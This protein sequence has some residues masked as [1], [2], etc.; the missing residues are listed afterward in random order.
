MIGGKGLATDAPEEPANGLLTTAEL[1]ARPD[2]RL[3]AT[4]VSPSMRN[5][6]GPGGTADVEPRV[7]QVLVVLAD[8][9][10]HVVTRHTLF[11]R[12]WGGVYVGDDSLNRAVAAVR[13][14]AQDVAAGGFEI[15]TIPRTGYRLTIEGGAES[16]AGPGEGG[17]PARQPML[18]RRAAVGTGIAAVAVAGGG[19]GLWWSRSE[20]SR[21]FE[22]LLERGEKALDFGD[23][24]A[25]PYRYFQR[26]A[27]LRPDD[28]RAQAYLAYSQALRAD[29]IQAGEPG[30]VDEAERATRAT[31]AADP[32]NAYGQTAIILLQRSTLDIAS[33]EVRLRAVLRDSPAN[34]H[35][36]R[37]L[38][39]LLQSAGRSREALALVERAGRVKPLAAAT[40][41][42]RAQLL[43][44]LGRKAEADRVIDLALQYWPSHRFV[45]FARFTIFAFTDREGAALAMLEKP[46]T[47]PQQYSPAA[48][49]LWRV[50]LAALEQRSP[51][52]IATARSA[53]L[54]AAKKDLRLS[55]QAVLVLSALG[56]VDAAFEIANGLLQFQGPA[57]QRPQRTGK[58]SVVNSNGWRFS[59]WLFTPPIA[60][61]RADP[62]FKILCDGIGLTEYWSKLGV[63]PDYRR[64]LS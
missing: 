61:L 43:W 20:E 24:S 23:P 5:V 33:T 45:R 51:S 50:S 52:T 58:T 17:G 55:S 63:E 9:A 62:R 48:V 32:R 39:N 37:Q 10:N 34:I 47:T 8:A 11:S 13:R 60:A 15:E 59:P 19:F 49:A 56:E 53:N 16:A 26:A 21:R 29:N 54:A 28:V 4:L 42:P 3:G 36:M 25:S 40:H 41:Y 12:C 35:V 44:I 30:A 64:G 46:E 1:A 38:W 27:A 18:S 57:G 2:F 14:I 22:Q 31:L 7:M 6:R